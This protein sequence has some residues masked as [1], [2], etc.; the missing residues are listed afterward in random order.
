MLKSVGSCEVVKVELGVEK[1]DQVMMGR[2]DPRNKRRRAAR[3]D[4]TPLPPL[5][6]FFSFWSSAAGGVPFC[7]E[8][9]GL[10]MARI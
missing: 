6:K 2:R 5:D 7:S 9:G 10:C 1:M 4:Q 3:G 8:H